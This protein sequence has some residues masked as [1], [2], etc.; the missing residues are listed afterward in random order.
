MRNSLILIS[1]LFIM[2]CNSIYPYKKYE[3]SQPKYG[4]LIIIGESNDSL[5][6]INTIQQW[7]TLKTTD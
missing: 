7:D 3:K 5:K 2:S 6:H 1:L 4:C